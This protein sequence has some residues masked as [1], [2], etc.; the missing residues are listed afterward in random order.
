MH[1]GFTSTTLRQIKSLEKI[2]EIAKKTG[3]ECI[4]WGGDIHVTDVNSAKKAKKLCDNAGIRI[5]SYGSYYRVGSHDTAEWK[6]I[7]EIASAMDAKTVRVWLGKAD[8]E[9]TNEADYKKLVDDAKSMCDVAV[10]YGLD[11]C[12]ECHGNTYN[13]DTDAFLKIR[14]DIGCNNFTT[15]FQSLYRRKE[16]DLDRIE[17]T[18]PYIGCVHVSY[19]EQ[20]REQFPK[21]NLFYMDSLI[22]KLSDCGYDGDV[23]VEFV[24]FSYRYGVP[25]ALRKELETIRKTYDV[26]HSDG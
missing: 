11:V 26:K 16:Y 25:S 24:F 21:L 8:S 18:L 1:F 9:K 22:K 23:L 4:E 5:C 3:A 7:C 10:Q 13:N 15:Y 6:K 20:F 12:P 19:F 17:R 14:E 2:V